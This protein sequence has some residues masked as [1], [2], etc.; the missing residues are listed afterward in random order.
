MG[1]WDPPPPLPP[2]LLAGS[3]LGWVGWAGLGWAGLGWAGLGWGLGWVLGWGWAGLGLGWVGLGWAGWT[4]TE[5]G[6]FEKETEVGLFEN[7]KLCLHRKK[8]AS[9][10]LT[11]TSNFYLFLS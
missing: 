10:W 8:G 6:F 3:G 9:E 2:F 7:G 1:C 4:E 5:I 11:A